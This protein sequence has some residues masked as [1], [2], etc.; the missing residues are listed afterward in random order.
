VISHFDMA[1]IFTNGRLDVL[2]S[3]HFNI[4]SYCRYLA[5]DRGLVIVAIDSDKRIEDK[6]RKLPIF[7]QD[8][9]LINLRI[10]KQNEKPLINQ[11]QIFNSDQ[12]LHDIISRLKPD[13]IVKGSEWE[14]QKIIGDDV[15]PVK[16]YPAEKNGMSDK[17]S[18]T[19]IVQTILERYGY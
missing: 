2:H 16:F 13:L 8:I 4:L 17:I 18:S 1:V 12:D 15:A 3:G 7:S 10:L 14:G 11:I 5:T 6:D 19:T 9:R